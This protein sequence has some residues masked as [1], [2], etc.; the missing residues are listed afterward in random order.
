MAWFKTKKQKQPCAKNFNA[1]Q[2]E[3]NAYEGVERGKK[4]VSLSRIIGSV[5]RYQDF[6]AQF[7]LKEHL[8]KER[9]EKIKEMMRTGQ[10]IPPVQ[11]YQIK[12]DFYV[13]DGNHRIA[14]AKELGHD[15]ILA[16][17]VE[18]IPSTL[19]PENVRYREKLAFQEESGLTMPIELTEM[20]QYSVLLTQIE[21]HQQYLIK[22]GQSVDFH[23]AAR[24]WHQT[25][26]LPLI[27]I[28]QKSDLLS[29]FPSRTLADLYIYITHHQWGQKN[30]DR[31]YGVGLNQMIPADME[32]FR[33]KMAEVQNV[34]YPEMKHTITVFVT[35][36]VDP[37][38]EKKI[39]DK[40]F[41]LDEVKEIHSIHG[42]VDLLAKVELTRT[43]LSSD[44]ETISNFVQNQFRTLTGIIS[45]QT[46][47][48]GFSKFKP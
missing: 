32:S 44:A 30:K 18:F 2:E 1:C 27:S 10:K 37:R 7:H 41:A 20:G 46:L 43:L 24:D 19:S 25:I 34:D 40:L 42:S 6:D 48:P 13:V 33:A 36:N 45:T 23:Q 22:T 12:D 31:R 29:A 4:S 15:E 9:L 3:E 26:Y 39:I 17:I 16:N 38:H 5:G 47:I 11:L 21:T 14:A 28:I 35:L 8:P